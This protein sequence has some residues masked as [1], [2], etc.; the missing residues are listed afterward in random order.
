METQSKEFDELF[1]T[2]LGEWDQEATQQ[3]EGNKA[4]LGEIEQK[5]HDA[6]A[7]GEPVKYWT[8]KRKKHRIMT[9][10]F[11]G[12]FVAY[13]ALVIGYGFSALKDTDY[14]SAWFWA[15]ASYSLVVITLV[16]VGIVVA[17]ARVLLRLFMSQLHLGNDADER[18][19]MVQTYLALRE[20]GHADETQMQLVIDRLFQR[21]TD[22]VVREELGPVTIPDAIRSFFQRE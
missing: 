11:G 8:K 4:A 5:Y 6:M 19:T 17:L 3:R 21:A 16:G 2:K 7:L 10:V 20:G 22:G 15:N 9:T 12:M 18:V 14:L 13:L 1:T